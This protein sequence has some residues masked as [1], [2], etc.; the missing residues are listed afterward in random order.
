MERHYLNVEKAEDAEIALASVF[1]SQGDS[2]FTAEKRVGECFLTRGKGRRIDPELYS[3]VK[4][5]KDSEEEIT[6]EFIEETSYQKIKLLNNYIEEKIKAIEKEFDDAGR[7]TKYINSL[8]LD[9]KSIYA[10]IFSKLYGTTEFHKFISPNIDI[11]FWSTVWDTDYLKLEPK[12]RFYT[13]KDIISQE[14]GETKLLKKIKDKV[15]YDRFKIL[16]DLL[17]YFE[18]INRKDIVEIIL[19]RKFDFINTSAS[20]IKNK[21][22]LSEEDEEMI[23]SARRSYISKRK[24]DLNYSLI[25]VDI[26]TTTYK[27]R[28]A[29]IKNEIY[30]L[31]DNGSKV[32][33]MH[34]FMLVA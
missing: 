11:K 13:D 26:A 5:S 15:S 14:M 21:Y 23:S 8:V 19:V 6:E 9:L 10:I 3:S 22:K 16:D 18:D 1:F 4:S 34:D 25:L 7:V 27:K 32:N 33:I 20:G 30:D 2:Y 24:I 17:V 31:G 29:K 28:S 12:L